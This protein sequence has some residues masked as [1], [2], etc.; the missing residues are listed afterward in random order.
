MA[1]YIDKRLFCNI[2]CVEENVERGINMIFEVIAPFITPAIVAFAILTFAIWAWARG[3]II[4][5]GNIV[6]PSGDR[7]FGTSYEKI[8]NHDLKVLSKASN[9][10]TFAYTLFANCSAIFP[11][12]GIFGTVCSLMRLSGTDDISAS[13]SIALDTTVWGLVFAMGFKILDSF[14]SPKLDRALDAADYIIHMDDREK[15][16]KYAAQAEAG[17]RN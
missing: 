6:F 7:R 2:M 17:Y 4:V 8:T 3:E 9:R 12:L 11:L 10:A 5:L 13:F 16:I 1:F 14:I 15:R